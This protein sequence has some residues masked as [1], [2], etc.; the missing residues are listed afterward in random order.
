MEL[1]S[2]TTNDKGKKRT[3]SDM[4]IDYEFIFAVS[5]PEIGEEMRRTGGTVMASIGGGLKAS[6]RL[7][8]ERMLREVTNRHDSKPIKFKLIWA[9]LRSG[10]GAIS[11]KVGRLVVG[12]H[13]RRRLLWLDM[14]RV[15]QMQLKR[16][17]AHYI[18]GPQILLEARHQAV[19]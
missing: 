2:A 13:I 14:G 19:P 17:E 8:K 4:T 16:K 12:S 15:Q 6:Q 9:G 11:K 10:G 1:R 7:T 18:V 3:G 5:Y